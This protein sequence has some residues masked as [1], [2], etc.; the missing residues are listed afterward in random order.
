[1]RGNGLRVEKMGVCACFSE[2]VRVF[3]ARAV[4]V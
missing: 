2:C 1:M 3:T 4:S